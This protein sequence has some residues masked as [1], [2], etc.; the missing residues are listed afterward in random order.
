[1]KIRFRSKNSLLNSEKLATYLPIVAHFTLFRVIEFL[2]L[3]RFPLLYFFLRTRGADSSISV[4][5][6]PEKDILNSRI[7]IPKIQPRIFFL[8]ARVL[9]LQQEIYF[10][11]KIFFLGAR[12][13]STNFKKKILFRE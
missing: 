12:I 6:H 8:A 9:F 11:D 3:K 4:Y 2:L 10:W 1:V 13:F 5:T 7:I